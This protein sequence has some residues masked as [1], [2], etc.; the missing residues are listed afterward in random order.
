MVP[1][2]LPPL[3]PPCVH[4][5]NLS[6]ESDKIYTYVLSLGVSTVETN[7]DRDEEFLKDTGGMFDL[8]FSQDS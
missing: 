3:P 6:Y 2:R 5:W 7:Q 8:D 4:L 1:L